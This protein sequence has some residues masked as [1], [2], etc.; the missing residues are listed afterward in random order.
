MPQYKSLISG[1]IGGFSWGIVA[2]AMTFCGFLAQ[3]FGIMNV[4]IVV[5]ELSDNVVLATRNLKN[6]LLLEANEVNVLDL[7]SANLV[8]A[9]EAAIKEIEEAL[10]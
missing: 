1:F 2:V 8:I 10:A 5:S 3:K 6:V 7:V 9:E 4:L